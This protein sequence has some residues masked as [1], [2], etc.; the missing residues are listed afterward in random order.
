[1]NLNLENVQQKSQKILSL[2]NR[3]QTSKTIDDEYSTFNLFYGKE[4][5]ESKQVPQLLIE[6]KHN[7]SN[8]LKAGCLESWRGG[9][10]RHFKA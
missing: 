8:C 3:S 4:L 5:L 10:E 1:M 9:Q 7:A 6:R 2:E